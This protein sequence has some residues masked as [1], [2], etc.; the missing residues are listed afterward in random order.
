LTRNQD[1]VPVMLQDDCQSIHSPQR[2]PNPPKLVARLKTV[3]TE[4]FVYEGIRESLIK[5]SPDGVEFP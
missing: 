4:I 3:D 1:V 2:R 5:S